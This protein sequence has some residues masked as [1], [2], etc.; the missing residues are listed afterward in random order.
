MVTS[1]IIKVWRGMASYYEPN[2][3]SALEKY[4][5]TPPSLFT[6]RAWCISVEKHGVLSIF[7]TTTWPLLESYYH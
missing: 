4:G 2:I 7:V 5:K 6:I 1:V 3:T